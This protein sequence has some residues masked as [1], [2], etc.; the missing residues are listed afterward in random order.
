MNRSPT[1]S[2]KNMTPEEAWSGRRPSVD[3]FQI[4]GCIAYT[5]VPDEKRKKL[6]DK[7]EKCIFLG[8][9][10]ASKA[11]KLL[12][13]LTKKIVISRDVIFDEENTRDWSVQQSTPIIFK[14]EFEEVVASPEI[15]ETSTEEAAETSPPVVPEISETP[16]QT[17]VETLPSILGET[18]PANQPLRRARRRPSWMSDYE[19][20]G[21]EVNDDAITHFALF[22]YCEPTVFE[23]VV[24]EEKWRKAMDAEI[25]AIEKN[26]TW[27]LTDLP[28]K[29]KTIGVKWVYKTKLKENGEID[30]YKVR[31]V[32]K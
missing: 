15:S 12:N 8:V 18:D 10:E 3:H 21:I 11:Y 28:E 19:V 27:E 29:Q 2:V 14:N 13:P 5:H 16:T 1:I 6:D 20:K 22:A 24:R 17:V 23:S 4:F 7:S 26:D 31:L 30:K 32:A 25:E 9:S